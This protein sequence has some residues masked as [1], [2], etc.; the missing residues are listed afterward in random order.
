MLTLLLEYVR[1]TRNLIKIKL[2]INPNQTLP[3]TVRKLKK[4]HHNIH[5]F[6]IHRKDNKEVQDF[7][8][9]TTTRLFQASF[10]EKYGLT[11]RLL[12]Y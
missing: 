7:M 5:F 2:H 12:I 10:F 6:S 8:I 11:K 3:M 9:L 1:A 4:T